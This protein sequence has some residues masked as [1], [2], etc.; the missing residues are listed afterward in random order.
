VLPSLGEGFGITVLEAMSVGVPVVAANR[1]ALPEVL[2]D[3]GALVEP[4]DP[5]AMASAIER[6]ID[7]RAFAAQCA[8]KGI[9]RSRQFN[10][11]HTAARVYESYQLAIE[12]KRAH[13]D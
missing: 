3:A 8:A 13:R 12:N 1:G 2:G 11:K 5:E 7:D 9:S 6:M 4:D 10:W